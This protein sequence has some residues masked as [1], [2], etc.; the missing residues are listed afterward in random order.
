MA[1]VSQDK[2]QSAKHPPTP[3]THQPPTQT[4]PPPN[5]Q[6]PHTNPPWRLGRPPP[7]PPPTPANKWS[8]CSTCRQPGQLSAAGGVGDRGVRLHVVW[9]RAAAL[10]AWMTFLTW[11]GRTGCPGTLITSGDLGA[12]AAGRRPLDA[13]GLA[14]LTLW[15]A[16]QAASP[17][18]AR[19]AAHNRPARRTLVR[20]QRFDTD[21]TNL[22]GGTHRS[23]SAFARTCRI[24][25]PFM[26]ASSKSLAC[27]FF[28]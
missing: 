12:P 13:A 2:T 26:R 20:H 8:V 16:A 7:T 1:C 3:T 27:C 11:P 9:S 25:G 28:A 19:R 4:S 14:T 21:S 24:R 5:P 22:H 6:P 17:S 15:A 23:S 18:T 10:S